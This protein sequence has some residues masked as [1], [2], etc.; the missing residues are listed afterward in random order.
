MTVR[1]RNPMWDVR[2]RYL[3]HVEE[4]ETYEGVVYPNQSHQAGRDVINLATGRTDWKYR[5][6]LV[7]RIV[8]IDGVETKTKAKTGPKVWTVQGSKGMAY[9]VVENDGKRSC[10]CVGFK[11]HNRCKHL[12]VIS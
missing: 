7:D 11:Y 8:S 12:N 9:T 10:D 5:E 2:D 1:Y 4:F 6:L 3:F